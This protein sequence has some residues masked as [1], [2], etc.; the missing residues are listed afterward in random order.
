MLTLLARLS[1]TCMFPGLLGSAGAV[2]SVATVG[3]WL[4]Q[5]NAVNSGQDSS[6]HPCLR[7]RLNS[8][9][10][11]LWA[12]GWFGLMLSTQVKSFH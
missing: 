7:W 9:L 4:I 1:H 2:D 11:L 10:L 8:F 6:L 5:P 12:P 3:S